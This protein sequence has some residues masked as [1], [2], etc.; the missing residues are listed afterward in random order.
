MLP[1]GSFA[2]AGNMNSGRIPVPDDSARWSSTPAGRSTMKVVCSCGIIGL[3]LH[4]RITRRRKNQETR[5]ILH[6]PLLGCAL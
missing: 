3:A 1:T 6:T 2:A 5:M 4:I